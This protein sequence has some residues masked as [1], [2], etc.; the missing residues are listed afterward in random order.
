MARGDD[1]E[2]FNRK[3]AYR[4]GFAMGMRP[5]DIDAM[6]LREFIAA[7]TA[8]SS[9]TGGMTQSESDELWEWIREG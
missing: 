5:A 8:F 7:V 3:A 1:G 6:T 4:S 9:N 2:P